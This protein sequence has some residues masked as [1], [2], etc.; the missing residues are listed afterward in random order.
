MGMYRGQIFGEKEIGLHW[1]AHKHAADHADDVGKE[2]RM[3][4]AICLGGPPPVMFSAISPLPDNLSEYEFAGLLNKKRLR[5]TKCL[6]ND[7]WVPAE[8]DFVIEGY[9]I[10][11]ETRTEGPFGDHFGYY[12]LEEEYPV[13]H[14]TAITH[15]KNPTIPMTIVGV[16]PMED[17]Y[18]GEAIGDAFRPVLQF[19]HRDVKDLFLPLETGFHNLAIVASKQRYPRQARKTALGLMGAGQMMFLKSI[20][21]VDENHDVK[22]LEALLKAVD[23]NVRIP[24]DLIILDGMVADSLAHASPWQNVHSKLI[25]DATTLT[26]NDPRA[27]EPK[28]MGCP[29]SLSISASEAKAIGNRIWINECGGTV[30]GLT[31]WNKGEYFASLGIGHFIWYHRIKRGPYEESFPSLVRYLVSKGVNVPEF[32]FNKHCPW[33]TREDFVKAKNSPQMIEL[34]NLLFSSIPLQTEFILLRLENAQP[35]ML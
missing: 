3:P 14:V 31:S 20:I 1:Q 23:Y 10:P 16:P 9:T 35:K 24:E 25:I 33:E 28:M 11:G 4:V 30:E 13:M 22:D 8:V 18:L 2:N 19:Q 32:I 27:N 15:R 29:D 12:C 34:R 21:A 17:G 5:I 26:E 7:L 6:T